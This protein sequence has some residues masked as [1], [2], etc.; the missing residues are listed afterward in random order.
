MSVWTWS[1]GSVHAETSALRRERQEDQE[2]RMSFSYIKNLKLGL[3]RW[4]S[5]SKHSLLFQRS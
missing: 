1:W 5:G 4:L 2:F 3:K